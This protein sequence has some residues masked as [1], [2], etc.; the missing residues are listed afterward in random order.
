VDAGKLL[1]GR[2]LADLLQVDTKTIRNWIDRGQAPAHFF[3]PG[4][5]VRFRAANVALWL[6]RRGCEVPAAMRPLLPADARTAADI[7]E[8]S[9]L[10]RG[11]TAEER[12]SLLAAARR[13]IDGRDVKIGADDRSR[14]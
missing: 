9:E 12:D 4:R 1:S 3:T 6:S 8:L 7:D 11:M 14:S 5:H 2:Y 13:I 10:C